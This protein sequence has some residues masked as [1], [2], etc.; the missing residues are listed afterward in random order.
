MKSDGVKQ[1]RFDLA[2]TNGGATR[3]RLPRSEVQILDPRRCSSVGCAGFTVES[4]PTRA[5]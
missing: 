4:P 5:E 2:L 3:P 1:A